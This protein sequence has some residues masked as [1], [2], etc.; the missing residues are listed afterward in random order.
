MLIRLPATWEGIQADKQLEH[1]GIATHVVLIYRSGT[2]P[3]GSGLRPCHVLHIC[4]LEIVFQVLYLCW[5]KGLSC[6]CLF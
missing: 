5:E 6:I 4:L 1:E 3:G 2:R